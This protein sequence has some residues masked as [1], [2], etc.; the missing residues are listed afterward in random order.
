[1]TQEFFSRRSHEPSLNATAAMRPHDD[2]LGLHDFNA[3]LDL[4]IYISS[5]DL[6]LN[7]D[8]ALFHFGGKV[9]QFSLR[10]ILHRFH[11][12]RCI[13]RVLVRHYRIRCDHMQEMNSG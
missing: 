6:V 9:F 5:A 3:S 11:D 10:G 1:M 4:L 2:N 7:S 8:A 12:W 13:D